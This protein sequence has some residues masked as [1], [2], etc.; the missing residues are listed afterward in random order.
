M[1]SAKGQVVVCDL[2]SFQKVYHKGPIF[3]K[4]CHKW[5]YFTTS[6]WASHA[7]IF[8]YASKKT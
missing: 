5:I 7:V 6:K 2:Q 8:F 1:S 3:R 4:S